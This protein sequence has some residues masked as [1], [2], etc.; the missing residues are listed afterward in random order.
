[1][2]AENPELQ[3]I[4][5]RSDALDE[6][7]RTEAFTLEPGTLAED[8]RW[9]VFTLLYSRR[10]IA[11]HHTGHYSDYAQL[12]KEKETQAERRA[13]IWPAPQRKQ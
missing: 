10:P 4:D 13:S 2:L 8:V 1:M 6:Q 3:D 9:S 12:Q 11:R 7:T 5:I